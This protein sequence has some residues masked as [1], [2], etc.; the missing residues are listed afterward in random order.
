[1]KTTDM[2]ENYILGLGLNIKKTYKFIPKSD[3]D[4]NSKLKTETLEIGKYKVE[5]SKINQNT[6]KFKY[7]L[8]NAKNNFIDDVEI[9]GD[10]GT[11]CNELVNNA[12]IY[13]T[14]FI[15]YIVENIKVKEDL[16]EKLIILCNGAITN[17]GNEIQNTLS[18]YNIKLAEAKRESDATRSGALAR[19]NNKINTPRETYV[20]IYE[21]DSIF[22]KDI[23]AQTVNV[24]Y[25]ESMKDAIIAGAQNAADVIES[26]NINIVN[27]KALEEIKKLKEK[28]TS[29]FNNNLVNL[30]S[31]KLDD[32][33]NGETLEKSGKTIED[34]TVYSNIYEVINELE[35]KDF[36]NYKLVLDFFEYNIINNLKTDVENNIFNYFIKEGK[37]DYNKIDYKLYV[38]LKSDDFKAGSHLSTR[39][40][41]YYENPNQSFSN[42][43]NLKD[44]SSTIEET[45]TNINNC[46]YLT[47]EEK[48]SI[49]LSLDKYLKKEKTNKISKIYDII[50]TILLIIFTIIAIYLGIK[51]TSLMK[52]TDNPT[53][54]LCIIGIPALIIG[55]IAAIKADY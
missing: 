27:D 35:E 18:N 46:K 41:N 9:K 8:W 28:I 48:Q 2:V 4:Y 54:L 49:K 44:L 5:L 38:Y 17:L 39:I 15:K 26:I 23:Y 50:I 11:C 25:S 45:K 40:R 52:Y 55:V 43:K 33:F 13:Y 19:A 1:M 12:L 7:M 24:G 31:T 20:R 53:T 36:E 32:V 30:L 14:D 51:Y 3:Y 22:G 6:R 21:N 47:N 10:I 37:D 29:N 16:T 42:Y 34:P